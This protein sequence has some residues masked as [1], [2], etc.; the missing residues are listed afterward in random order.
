MYR[1]DLAPVVLFVYNRPWHT[2]QTLNALIKNDLASLSNLIVYSDGAK[3]DSDSIKVNSVRNY[4]KTIVGFNSIRIIE[5]ISNFGLGNNIIGGVSE[6]LKEFEK[7]I[8]LEDDL[9]TSPYFLRYMNEGLRKYEGVK[10][11][12]SIHS[13]IYPIKKKLPETFFIKGADCLGWATWKDKWE[14]F[15]PDGKKLLEV[16]ESKG[17]TPEFDFNN[18]YPFTQMLKDQIAGKNTSWAVRWY[19]SAFINDMLT[20]YPGRSLIYHNGNDG[21]GTNFGISDFIDVKISETPIEMRD[22]GLLENRVERKK[23]ELFFKYNNAS[24][25][26]IIYR[27]IKRYLIHLYKSKK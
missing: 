9:L 11:V 3:N 12:I 16:L 5:R 4:L 23:I 24:F 27:K 18:A 7:I 17:L 13:F 19:A 10:N 8:V 14:V 1:N 26:R 22:I 6:T 21:S 25:I 15:E 2:E 20:L